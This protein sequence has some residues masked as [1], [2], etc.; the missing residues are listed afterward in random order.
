MQTAGPDRAAV[1]LARRR[2]QRRRNWPE[3]KQAPVCVWQSRC[4]VCQGGT[5]MQS[6]LTGLRTSC[7]RGS[8]TADVQRRRLL[9]GSPVWG[10]GCER[11]LC[12]GRRS[13]PQA[14]E[15]TSLPASR[16]HRSARAPQRPWTHPSAAPPRPPGAGRCSAA[17]PA[18]LQSG[19]RRRPGP[20]QCKSE[21]PMGTG[22]KSSTT[23][24]AQSW[25][26]TAVAAGACCRAA[27]AQGL[28]CILQAASCQHAVLLTPDTACKPHSAW[29]A[30]ACCH[31][32]HP[33]QAPCFQKRCSSHMAGD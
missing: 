30:P 10:S 20:L 6:A 18:G 21:R 26:H 22:H 4:T 29:H 9:L 31:M 15:P 23:T 8:A 13:R 25:D 2:H 16:W 24:L 11:E 3:A 12:Q 5:S 33:L 17:L 19:L 7:Y 28:P 32:L 27:H 1:M 14:G